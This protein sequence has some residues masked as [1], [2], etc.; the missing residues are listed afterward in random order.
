MSRRH[1]A[2]Q[3]QG[4]VLTSARP[5]QRL[6]YSLLNLSLRAV[7]RPLFCGSLM[8]AAL[9]FSQRMTFLT[10]ATDRVSQNG[11]EHHI[12]ALVRAISILF[13]ARNFDRSECEAL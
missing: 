11:A 3:P 2:V 6:C 12:S 9:E 13:F 4:H 10:S 5:P 7:C 8:H 1:V